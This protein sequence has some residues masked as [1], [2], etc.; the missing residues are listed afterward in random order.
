VLALESLLSQS[1]WA[2]VTRL[3]LELLLAQA[4]LW[5]P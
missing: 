4:Q 1:L 5:S 3:P 2:L